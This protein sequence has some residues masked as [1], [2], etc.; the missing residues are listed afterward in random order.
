MGLRSLARRRSTRRRV[1][2]RGSGDWMRLGVGERVAK[3]GV[4][5][6]LWAIQSGEVAAR[7]SAQSARKR[8]AT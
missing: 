4:Y 1:V 5:A 7:S 2:A 3:R 6:D 8:L